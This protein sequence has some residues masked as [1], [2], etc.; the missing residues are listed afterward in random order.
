VAGAVVG[1]GDA[2]A[3]VGGKVVVADEVDATVV[4]VLVVM[5]VVVEV[6]EVEVEV[7]V[8]VEVE[9]EERTLAA[10]T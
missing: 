7:E 4:L 2:D 10:P 6:V 1:S 3:V 5:M 8:V 9:E